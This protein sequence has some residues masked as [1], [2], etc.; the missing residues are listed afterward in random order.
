M[1]WAALTWRQRPRVRR[2]EALVELSHLRDAVLILVLAVREVAD[3]FRAATQLQA[4][5]LT[6]AGAERRRFLVLNE[7]VRRDAVLRTLSGGHL[8][9]EAL[10]GVRARRR[11]RRGC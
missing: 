5:L 7:V 10:H 9:Q 2:H 1:V 6:V 8:A 4:L 11:R 3:R